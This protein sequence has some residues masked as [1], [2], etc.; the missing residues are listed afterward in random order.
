MVESEIAERIAARR[1]ELDELEEQLV[2]QLDQVRDERDELAVAE[3]VWRRM[4]ERFA[5]ERVAAA[6]AAVQ[7]A[8]R[9]V[10]LVPHREGGVDEAVLPEYQRILAAVRQA[11]APVATRAV[12]ETLGLDTG[13]RGKLEP[14]RGKLTR[15]AERGWLRKQSDGRYS[16]RLQ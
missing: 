16:V 1:A 6:P 12:G 14:L 5:G 9:A 4:A 10:L 8:G 3:R 11:G 13:V 7:V 2:K 15:L